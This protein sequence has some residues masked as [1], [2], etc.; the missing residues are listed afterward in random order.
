MLAGAIGAGGAGLVDGAILSNI[1]G[2]LG[3]MQ[4]TNQLLQGAKSILPEN[5][6]KIS[7]S[8]SSETSSSKL[9]PNHIFPCNKSP[10]NSSKLSS[11]S[12]SN[13]RNHCPSHPEY[14]QRED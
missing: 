2:D 9:N 11:K 8:F 5:E 1:N 6:D 12:H 4:Q 13:H 10:S 3:K 7:Y 14:R